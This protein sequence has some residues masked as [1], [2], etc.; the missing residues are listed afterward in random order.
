MID[1]EE[2]WKRETLKTMRMYAAELIKRIDAASTD[3]EIKKWNGSR[4]QAAVKRTS[5]DLGMESAKF[6]AG[7]GRT[8][9]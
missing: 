3:E 2:Q 4:A 7:F 8:T 6:R 5:L 9:S 1:K